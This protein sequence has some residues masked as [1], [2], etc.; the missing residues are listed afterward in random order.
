[1]KATAIH[2]S[3][4]AEHCLAVTRA[5]GGCDACAQACPHEAITITRTVTIDDINCTGC[6]LCVHACP[7][8]ALSPSLNYQAGAAL[9]CSKV[10]GGA[11]TTLC[12]GRLQTSDIIALAGKNDTITLIHGDCANCSIGTP[13]VLEHLNH[14]ITSANV[15][16]ELLGRTIIRPDT[17]HDND[18]ATNSTKTSEADSEPQAHA[19]TDAR[20]IAL[21][22]LQREHFDAVDNPALLN[23]RE[24]L[25]GGWRNIQH[26]ASDVLAPLER[27]ADD[28]ASQDKSL[29]LEH[30][31]KL[32]V[33]SLADLLPEQHVPFALPRVD[34]G[35]IM[36]PKCTNVCPTQ[37][38]DRVFDEDSSELTL[39][40]ERCNGCLACVASCPK[41][42]IHLDDIIT[43]QE[44]DAEAR[45]VFHY[46][47]TPKHTGVAR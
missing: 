14:S 46:E 25:R 31:K 15:L 26:S 42:V 2:P 29:P 12:L 20:T 47:N 19:A 38:F 36:C 9:K 30:Q 5:T 35:C 24:L 4:K 10:K 17:T 40:S 28:D 13:K 18:T 27:F 7:S 21:H 39:R 32:H 22:L 34:E 44:L 8:Q 16:L 43:W 23:R 3:Y 11:N 33:L 6:G 1:M 45:V 37:A 41:Q